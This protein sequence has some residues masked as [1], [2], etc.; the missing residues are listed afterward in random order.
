MKKKKKAIEKQA[1]AYQELMEKSGNNPQKLFDSTQ[2]EID[3]LKEKLVELS[4]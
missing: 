2:K 1:K 3:A 4:L